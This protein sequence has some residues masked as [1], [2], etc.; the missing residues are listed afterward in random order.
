MKAPS[1]VRMIF[2]TE[3][4]EGWKLEEHFVEGFQLRS[5]LA[6]HGVRKQSF[7]AIVL[8]KTA[9]SV[10]VNGV[11]EFNS[12]FRC[13]LS[14]SARVPR[15]DSQLPLPR[16]SARTPRLAGTGLRILDVDDRFRRHCRREPCRWRSRKKIRLLV[17]KVEMRWGMTDS[18]RS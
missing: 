1:P 15:E 3:N 13:L 14:Q 11:V 4:E 18:A 10:V 5:A 6:F 9:S 12:R 17:E 8:S 16:V 2:F 7:P